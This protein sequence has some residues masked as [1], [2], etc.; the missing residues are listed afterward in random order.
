MPLT[1]LGAGDQAGAET[2]KVTNTKGGG[3]GSFAAAVQIANAGND[4]DR[5]LF[6]S[7]LSGDI[8]V[9]ARLDSFRDVVSLRSKSDEVRLVRVGTSAQLTFDDESV[10]GGR[11]KS[12]TLRGLELVDVV[13]YATGANLKVR[14]STISGS[15]HP[16]RDGIYANYDGEIEVRNSTISG[17]D[18]GALAL[19]G[20]RVIVKDSVIAG[21]G[22][23]VGAGNARVHVVR[24][25]ITG[26]DETGAS[27]VY[28]GGVSIRNSTLSS[29]GMALY[30]Y[31]GVES[32][33]VTGNAGLIES[34]TSYEPTITNSVVF[35][36][37]PPGDQP[38]CTPGIVV[39]G[40]GNV[41]EEGNEVCLAN[42]LPSDLF[43]GN[44]GLGPLAENGGPTPT[45]ALAPDSPALDHAID[46]EDPPKTDQRGVKRG[47]SPDSGS[48]ELK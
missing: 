1:A 21:N 29:N 8:P 10:R 22:T 40:G 44:A 16:Q 25:T 47:S 9:P 3:K 27:A 37:E 11:L 19:S 7:R 45:H 13:V 24:S 36:N 34:E 23:G 6:V 30:G 15:G 26:N 14:A 28:Y 39:S 38:V 18:V 43:T 17:W 4:R 42:D 32:S 31:A 35:A 33:T 46:T 2:I 5:I 20:S 48:F 12:N 41:F